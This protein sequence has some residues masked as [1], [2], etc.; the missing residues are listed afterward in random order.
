VG[1][2]GRLGRGRRW[3]WARFG[4]IQRALAGG[5][6]LQD[7][8]ALSAIRPG[9]PPGNDAIQEMLTLEAEGLL[10]R[11]G[12]LLGILAP[13]HRHAIHPLDAVLVEGELA[14][15][16]DVVEDRHAAIAHDHEPLLL[17]G[18][19]PADEDVAGDPTGKAQDRDRHVGQIRVQV[20]GAVGMDAR[21]PLT[22]ELKNHEDVVGGEA[23]ED[24]LLS[25]ELPEVE[26]V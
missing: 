13:R 12:D 23:P 5:Q 11:K 22:E 18:M 3:R 2:E 19:E 10:G 1:E 4:P 21:G 14:L 24:V 20:V 16:D 9:L 15:L 6:D 8:Q 25:Q 7:S 26:A 17:V